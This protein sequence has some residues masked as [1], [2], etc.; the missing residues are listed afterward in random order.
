M[1]FFQSLMKLEYSRQVFDNIQIFYFIWAETFHPDRQTNT[2]N[3]QT[4]T[5]K[6]IISFRNFAKAP[7]KTLMHI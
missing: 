6:L 7:K 2:R 3:R 4:G 1:L 5:R